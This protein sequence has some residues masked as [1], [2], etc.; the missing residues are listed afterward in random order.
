MPMIGIA[1]MTLVGCR[2]LS[3]RANPEWIADLDRTDTIVLQ[4]DDATMSI[5][6]D[7]TIRRLADIYANAKW[8]PYWHTLP[9]N[10]DRSIDLFADGDKLQHFS[11]TGVLWENE[12]YDS[13]RTAKLADADREW[14]ERLFAGI[15]TTNR[16]TPNNVIPQ[17][18]ANGAALRFRELMRCNSFLLRCRRGVS[19]SSCGRSV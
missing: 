8:E 6:D 15:P 18:S 13:N 11:Y 19:A 14:I 3:S 7:A 9:G 5:T 12:R 17:L 16:K 1:W 2:S 4:A 10:W